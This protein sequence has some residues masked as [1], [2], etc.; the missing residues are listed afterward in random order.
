MAIFHDMPAR[1]M[2]T[3]APPSTSPA[4]EGG[5]F[6]ETS[7]SPKAPVQPRAGNFGIGFSFGAFDFWVDPLLGGRIHTLAL[8]GH[9][10]IVTQD[11]HGENFGSTFWTSPQSD[12]DWPPSDAVDKAP[13][14]PEF[15]D[16]YFALHGPVCS[17]F[18]IRISKRFEA[19]DSPARVRI[20]YS[21]H[22]A[23][24]E[25][26]TFAPWE[27][28]RVRGGLSF[29]PSGGAGF[30]LPHLPA[31]HLDDAGGVSWFEY[32]ERC[33]ESD[34]KSFAN[35]PEG[36]LAHLE[37]DLLFI[38]S[39]PRIA[40]SEQAPGEAMVEIYARGDHTYIELEEQGAYTR[41][42]PG[43]ELKYAVDWLLVRVPPELSRKAGS[44][45]LVEFVRAALAS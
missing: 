26:V 14:T 6:D 16:G 29:F 36:W 25:A 13:Y 43:N 18:G 9:N 24:S 40:E 7:P 1:D 42:D 34:Q 33:I 35:A 3:P 10:L 21:I 4:S 8:D 45:E 12:W 27:V 2:M 44:P 11:E 20:S 28:T 15:G 23:S 31:V 19:T 41:I 30:K 32:D 5:A 17:R 38:K 39:F 22:N 37:K